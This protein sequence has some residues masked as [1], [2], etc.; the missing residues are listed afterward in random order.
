MKTLR[1]VLF[2]RHQA[3][4]PTL[5]AIRQKVVAGLT[6]G[7]SAK[8]AARSERVDGDWQPGGSA[9]ASGWRQLLWS[10]RW[11]LAGMAA[12]WLV[13]A[14]LSIDRT[15]ASA[16]DVTRRGAPSPRQLLA[17]LLENQRQ[18]R[19][20]IGTPT[21]EPVTVPPKP[22]STPHSQREPLSSASA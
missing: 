15:P 21:T 6:P 2:G 7:T 17:T 11:H 14:L 5:D 19:E 20:L 18:L 9:L 22:T 4:E 12:A 13:A 10:L 3:A 8:A 16:W 1:E